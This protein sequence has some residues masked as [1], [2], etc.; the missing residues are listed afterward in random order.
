MFIRIDAGVRISSLWRDFQ[1]FKAQLKETLRPLAPEL[2]AELRLSAFATARIEMELAAHNDGAFFRRHIDTQPGVGE[3]SVGDLRVL[4][5]VYY[6]HAE[7]KAFS[8]G[9]LRLHA[10]GTRGEGEFI[11][12]EPAHNTLVFFPAWMPHE[13]LPVSCPSKRF[14][15][16]RFAINCW[17]RKAV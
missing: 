10:P 12:V 3:T 11:D 14:A 1:P 15:D 9:A 5:G 13:V 16:S 6:F 17:F 2:T 7:P 8:G 4:S